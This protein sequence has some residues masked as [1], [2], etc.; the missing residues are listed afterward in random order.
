MRASRSTCLTRLA[1][2]VLAVGGGARLEAAAGPS[3]LQQLET[4]QTDVRN[5]NV[6]SFGN[7]NFTNY[8]DT[9]GPLAILG[10][11]YLD[12]GSVADQP[13]NFGVSSD[14]TLYVTGQLTLTGTT[15]LNSGYASTPGLTPSAWTWNAT[16]RELS[17]GGGDLNSTNADSAA[18]MNNPITNAAPANWNW[19]TLS[20]QFTSISQTLANAT[21]TGTITVNS[22]NLIFT[23]PADPATGVA[24][25]TLD[26]S[27]ISGNTYNGQTFSNIQINVP[28]GVTDVINVINA[29]GTTIFGS[30]ANFNTGTNDSSLLWNVE[31]S[32]TVTL[33]A[34][35]FIGAILAPTATIDNGTNT[36]VSG[37]I[38]ADGFNDTGAETHF[39]SFV[40]ASV[41][42]PEPAA[43][44]W[45]AVGL[46]GLGILVRRRR[47]A[48]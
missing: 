16:Q 2:G 5:Y 35:Q 4:F 13:G 27:K 18:S 20:T 12:G 36:A 3:V 45:C 33:G 37:Q 44:T 30:G 9:Q 26:A 28:T 23:A 7:S 10:N 19:N 41:V 24:V 34:G 31:G 48:S 22:N 29:A 6:I 17:G 25:F 8:G 46:C 15:T 40:V 21:T 32:G 11:L 47:V 43:F 38:V 14:P 39:T 42:V 1:L